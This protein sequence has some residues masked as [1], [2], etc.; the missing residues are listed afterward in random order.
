[1]FAPKSVLAFNGATNNAPM[2]IMKRPTP[3]AVRLSQA[4]KIALTE[5]A[6]QLKPAET[7]SFAQHAHQWCVNCV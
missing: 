4:E 7:I 1:M 3:L 6:K 2:G 5:I